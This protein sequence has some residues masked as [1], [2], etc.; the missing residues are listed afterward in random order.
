MKIKVKLVVLLSLICILVYIVTPSGLIDSKA[1][2][3]SNKFSSIGGIEVSDLK[4]SEIRQALTNGISHWISQSLTVTGSGTSLTLD[5]TTLQYDIDASID[6]YNSLTDKPWYAFWKSET[7]VNIPL[8]LSENEALKEEI[9]S[10]TP[11]TKPTAAKKNPLTKLTASQTPPTKPTAAKKNPPT[12]LT[13]SQTPK[14][15]TAAAKQTQ[16]KTKKPI[17]Q[18]RRC[19]FASQVITPETTPTPLEH[20]FLNRII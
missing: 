17:T 16:D 14:A 20:I 9:A 18:K 19:F 6:E 10:Q 7:I 13:A 5:P 1:Y 8:K 2:A 4:D 12:K 3:D 15:K 11:L